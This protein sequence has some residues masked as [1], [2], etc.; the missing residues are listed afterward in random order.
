MTGEHWLFLFCGFAC[1]Y[2]LA[3]KIE[4]RNWR[5]LDAAQEEINRELADLQRV[6]FEHTGHVPATPSADKSTPPVGGTSGQLQVI[7]PEGQLPYVSHSDK[8]R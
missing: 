4:E 2:L 3:W 1:G 7:L 6:V 5:K 8:P